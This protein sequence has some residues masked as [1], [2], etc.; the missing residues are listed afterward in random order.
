MYCYLFYFLCLKCLTDLPGKRNNI[1]KAD[2]H[3]ENVE[4]CKTAARWNLNI[5]TPHLNLI[6]NLFRISSNSDLNLIP[7]L[8]YNSEC[9]SS[10]CVS[11]RQYFYQNDKVPS[12][13]VSYPNLWTVLIYAI[14]YQ[15]YFPGRL[16]SPE[17]SPYLYI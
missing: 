3:V 7:F 13:L 6:R 5:S 8:L 10:Y 4:K 14:L 1:D 17:V 2:D 11:Q 15:I 9:L 12:W 16:S